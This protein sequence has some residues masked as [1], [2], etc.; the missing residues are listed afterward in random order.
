M[1]P[2]RK[3]PFSFAVC[4]LRFAFFSLPITLGDLLES[5][6]GGEGQEMRCSRRARRLTES[7]SL[8]F[9]TRFQGWQVVVLL[10]QW[11]CWDICE[12]RPVEAG[13]AANRKPV[14][15]QK[16]LRVFCFCSPASSVV[17]GRWRFFDSCTTLIRWPPNGWALWARLQVSCNRSDPGLGRAQLSP[18]VQ[19]VEQRSHHAVQ[20]QLA[21]RD[22]VVLF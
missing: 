7:R 3:S 13:I 11:R 14:G 17:P 6:L 22:H 5:S 8:L 2:Q 21:R 10:R 9:W 15:P 1:R 16:G 20:R 19:P 4:G 18:N 12:S